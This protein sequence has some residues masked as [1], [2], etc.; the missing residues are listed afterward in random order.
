M[1]KTYEV[2]LQETLRYVLT[3][4]AEDEDDARELAE[5]LWR[6]STDPETEFGYEVIE[7]IEATSAE[8]VI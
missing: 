8:E 1:S 6:D 3:V 5:E 4:T 2:Q 7:S